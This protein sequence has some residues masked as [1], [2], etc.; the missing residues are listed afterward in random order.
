MSEFVSYKDL[1]YISTDI[2]GIGGAIKCA[3]ELFCVEEIPLYEA[4]GQGPHIYISITRSGMTTREVVHLLAK[5]LEIKER[6]I[7]YAGIKDKHALVIQTFSIPW[8]DGQ[9][10]A[11]M[12][13]LHVNSALQINWVKRH[14]NKIKTGHLLG[15]RFRIVV[16]EL[17]H[18]ALKISRDIAKVLEESGIANFYGVQRFGHDEKNIQDA[19]LI[20]EGSGPRD[21]WQRR[22]ILSAYQSA[23]FNT[24]LTMRIR[25]GLFE[26]L[27]PGDIAKK[28]DT[29]GLFDVED[30]EQEKPRFL[31][32]QITY[33]GPIYGK[34]MRWAKDDALKLEEHVLMD[35]GADIETLGKHHLNGS[36]RVARYFLKDIN[37]NS[38]ALGLEFNFELPKGSY[39]TIILREFMKNEC[40]IGT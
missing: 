1:P 38:H 20:F 14:Q 35:T 8:P 11:F 32:R 34:R 12:E 21:P 19:R 3:P 25:N 24:W 30:I 39:A 4:S 40:L 15:N 36:R 13:K 28:T 26:H 2:S 18:D 6:D 29:G 33:T 10:D 23:L 22:F 31:A 27:L 7:G 9:D 16:Q 5:I 37:I 17:C